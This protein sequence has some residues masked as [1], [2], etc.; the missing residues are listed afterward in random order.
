[1][2]DFRQ[3]SIWIHLLPGCPVKPNKYFAEGSWKLSSEN[4]ESANTV[5]G[6]CIINIFMASTYKFGGKRKRVYNVQWSDAIRDFSLFMEG[7]YSTDM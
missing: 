1:M 2:G 3:G 5:V 6:R 7:V 4:E